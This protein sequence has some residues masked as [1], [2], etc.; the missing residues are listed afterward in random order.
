MFSTEMLQN[1]QKIEVLLTKGIYFNYVKAV[2][3]LVM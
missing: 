3:L 2:L 1:Q